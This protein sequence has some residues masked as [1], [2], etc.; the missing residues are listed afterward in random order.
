MALF[1]LVGAVVLARLGRFHPHARFGLANG[2]T[3]AARRRRRRSSSRWRSSRRCSPIRARPGPRFAGVC[4]LLALD[5]V[6]GLAARRQ[7]LAS[8]F[9]ARFDMEVDAGADPR[10]RG[11]GVRAR[12]GRP[13]DPRR[14]ACCATPS[15]PPAPALPALARPLPPSRRRRAVCALAV[16]VLGLLLA[17]PVAPPLSAALAAVAFAALARLVRRRHRLAAAAAAMTADLVS[18]CGLARSLVIYR[19]RPW[20]IAALARFY[21]GFIG[22]GRPRLRRRRPRRQPHPGA[23]RAPARGSSRSSRS[24]CSTPSSAATCRRR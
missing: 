8:A 9:G 13:V 24:G 15:S 1:A 7:G 16:G 18:L 21:R 12:Q 10:A 19:A 5:G 2:I 6:D 22:P 20:K 14:S 3:A 4:L 23:A 17:P 11:D